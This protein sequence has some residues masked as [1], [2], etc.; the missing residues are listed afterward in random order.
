MSGDYKAA[1]RKRTKELAIASLGSECVECGANIDLQFDHI[2]FTTK[3]FDIS[4]GIRDGYSHTRI[5]AELAKCQLLCL[6]HH[7][8]KTRQE[9][10]NN[11]GGRNRIVDP[12]HGTAVMY[13]RENCRCES[14]Q[15]WKLAYRK[16]LV[17]SRGNIR[18]P[19]S[20]A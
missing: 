5:F 9:G 6:S 19:V 17:D 3:E 18:T 13:G 2:D 4:A 1:W 7:K 11:T 15:N 16:R 8:A 10:S 12:Q 14:C 20:I